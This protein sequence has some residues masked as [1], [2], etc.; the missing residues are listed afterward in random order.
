MTDEQKKKV[1]EEREAIIRL[2]TGLK[3]GGNGWGK[4]H[5]TGVPDRPQS[6]A[7]YGVMIRS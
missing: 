2:R 5:G 4:D 3:V 6:I 7:L 1:E